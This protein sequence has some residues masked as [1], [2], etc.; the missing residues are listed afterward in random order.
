MKYAVVYSYLADAERVQAMR[1]THRDY[2]R[3]LQADGRLFAAG[4]F[5]DGSGALI[6][7]NAES[8]AQVDDLVRNDPFNQAGVF[9]GWTI[10]EWDQVM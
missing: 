3:A 9:T 4:P 2:L 10:Y 6:I 7:Y 5:A 1:P 8:A